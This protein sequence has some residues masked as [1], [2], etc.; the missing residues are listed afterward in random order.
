MILLPIHEQILREI[1]LCRFLN[2][3]QITERFFSRGSKNYVRRFVNELLKAHY[4][5]MIDTKRVGQR[6]LYGLDRLGV[7]YLQESG[8]VISYYASEHKTLSG[9]QLPHH[10]ITNNVLIAAAKLPASIPTIEV[11]ERRHYISTRQKRGRHIPI[12]D[13]WIHLISRKEVHH[14]YGFWVEVDRGTEE[15]PIIREK[16][17]DIVSFVG[18]G[19][20]EEEF[21]IPGFSIFFLTTKSPYRLK[22]LK[23]WVEKELMETGRGNWKDFFHF[24]LIPEGPLK[25]HPTRKIRG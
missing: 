19:K 11:L 14:G 25:S 12:P 23:K 7:Q 22:S 5:T 20:Y 9:D 15:E 4:V 16:A 3:E 1:A 13:A 6:H 21:G 17:S 10:M 2:I 8:M 24:S 18:T